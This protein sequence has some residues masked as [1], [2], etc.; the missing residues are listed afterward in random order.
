MD[1]QPVIPEIVEAEE[2]PQPPSGLWGAWAT[3]GFGC[4]IGIVLLVIQ[5]IIIAVYVVYKMSSAS[6]PTDMIQFVS[7]IATNGFIIG[8][9]VLIVDSAG[10]LML[11]GIIKLKRGL[12]IADYLGFRRISRRTVLNMLPFVLAFLVVIYLISFIPGQSSKGSFVVEAYR[13]SGMRIIL[14]IDIVLLAPLFEETFFRGF[15]FASYRRTWLGITGTVIVTAFVWALLH[16]GEYNLVAVGA[17]FLFGL[18]LGAIR[19]KTDS[20]WAPLVLHA[21]YNGVVLA[22]VAFSM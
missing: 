4:L 22:I 8:I 20:I 2:V 21:V 12:S 5:A 14:W 3:T 13:N 6:P 18:V 10:L 16:F 1:T 17:L 9:S 15:V 19:E 11:A 7:S